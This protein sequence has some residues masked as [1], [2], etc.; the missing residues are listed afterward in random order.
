VLYLFLFYL[1]RVIVVH[2]GASVI[3]VRNTVQDECFLQRLW[4]LAEPFSSARLFFPAPSS[5]TCYLIFNLV[6][7]CQ[8]RWNS[9]AL[10]TLSLCCATCVRTWNWWKYRLLLHKLCSS[11]TPLPPREP[12]VRQWT[13]TQGENQARRSQD[14]VQLCTQGGGTEEDGT[15][16]HSGHCRMLLSTCRTICTT[17]VWYDQTSACRERE[18]IRWKGSKTG[19]K[20][21]EGTSS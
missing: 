13:W 8:W 17:K 12:L 6:Y 21:S 4:T 1:W 9:H 18:T 3:Q 15:V 19:M 14:K 20:V 2:T 11:M 16:E 10:L 7:Y 5:C